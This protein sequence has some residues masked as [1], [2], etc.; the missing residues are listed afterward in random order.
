GFVEVNSVVPVTW[1]NFTAE[2]NGKAVLLKWNTLQE[3]N[4]SQYIVERS[5][6]GISFIT[7]GS[8]TAAGNSNVNVSYSFNDAAPL[9]GINFFRLKQVD[10]DGKYIYSDIRQINFINPGQVISIS[11]NPAKDFIQLK[12]Y[13]E[14]GMTGGIATIHIY[15]SAMQLVQ[16]I[17]VTQAD[18]S[19]L[20][21]PVK[22][23]PPGIY[24]LQLVNDSAI[25]TI[26]FL[27]E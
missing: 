22:N 4:A 14:G 9:Q 18:R 16:T 3:Q 7:I 26:K 5:G 6:N 8:L 21:I 2:K 13:S 12:I 25:N 11:P 19:N 10:I 20:T 1:G 23:F 17:K 24:F 15:S 27:K